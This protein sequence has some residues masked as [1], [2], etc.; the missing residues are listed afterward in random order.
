MNRPGN[1][2]ASSRPRFSAVDAAGVSVSSLCLIH[3]LALPVLAG[4]LPLMGAWAE[5][6]W[7]HKA[8]VL[9]AVPISGYAVFANGVRF[10]DRLFI[11]LVT[12]GLALLAASAFIEAL[13]DF[14]QAMTAAGALLVAAGH[15][16]RW[17]R[18]GDARRR[19]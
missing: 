7:V 2:D 1:I 4:V 15:L 16:R 18:H 3:C 19:Q 14:E 6:E 5:A 12:S 9:L 8:F 13:H 17:R 11:F 10:R